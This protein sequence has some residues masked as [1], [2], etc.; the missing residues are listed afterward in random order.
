MTE[1]DIPPVALAP[2]APPATD[3]P[4]GF[5]EFWSGL[6]VRSRTRTA[7]RLEP[8]RLAPRGLAADSVTLPG[9]GDHELAGWFVTPA[10]PPGAVPG[11]V[12]LVPPGGRGKLRDHTWPAAGGCAHLVVEMRHDGDPADPFQREVAADA[13]RAVSE[14]RSLPGV[15]PSR[16]GVLG[17]AGAGP[18]AVAAAGLLQDVACV[19]AEPPFAGSCAPAVRAFARRAASPLLLVP[20][21]GA[22]DV[23]DA[24]GA[25]SAQVVAELS[26]TTA[27]DPDV[28]ERAV[29]RSGPAGRHDAYLR[30]LRDHT[31]LGPVFEPRAVP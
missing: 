31:E 18:A 16:V 6:L 12:Q 21:P 1:F 11:L 3:E 19:I 22:Q 2:A 24:W 7:T 8:V 10:D 25:H 23:L 29:D 26:G 14:M 30:W 13:V 17:R 27:P 20:G 4:A 5:D 9:L 28:V 15:D